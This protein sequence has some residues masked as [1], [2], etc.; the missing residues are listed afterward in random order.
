MKY[1]LFFECKEAQYDLYTLL[2]QYF[3]VER[4]SAKDDTMGIM[5][6][7]K[8]FLDP[9]SKSIEVLGNVI[10]AFIN[11]N[12]CSITV[13]NGEKEILFEGRIG[14]LS[15]EEIV[16]ILNKILTEEQ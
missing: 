7:I 3:E 14:K 12:R 16:D 1:E 13:K 11:A 2:S 9:V 5:D 4:V 15:S 10:I 8:V 6:A